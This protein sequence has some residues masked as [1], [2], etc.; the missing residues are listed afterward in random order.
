MVRVKT[1]S[2]LKGMREIV[3]DEDRVRVAVAGAREYVQNNYDAL[4]SKYHSSYVALLGDRGVIG[5]GPSQSALSDKIRREM[6]LG[7]PVIIN[8][9]PGML[10]GTM[11]YKNVIVI[12]EE[13]QR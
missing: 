11:S 3:L 2:D 4:M 8:T 1:L 5:S 13:T 9:I 6:H 10:D 7:Q 12:A